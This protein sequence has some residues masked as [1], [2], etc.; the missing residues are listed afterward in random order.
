MAIVGFVLLRFSGRK[1]ITQMSIPTTIVMI[2]IGSIIVQPI[3]E[4]SIINTIA[5]VAMFIIVLVVVEWLQVKFNLMEK[6]MS[7]SSVVV[8]KD[9]KL[10]LDQMRKIRL[11]V[12]KLEMKIRQ[13][14]ITSYKQ[15]KVATI[16]PNGQLGY[17]LTNDAKPLTVGQFKQLLNVM[18]QGTE[19]P[20]N[21][22]PLFSEVIND[23]HST[24]PDERYD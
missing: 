14:G 10:Q 12:D 1:S 17:E 5:A 16:E 4:D 9:G 7:G 18:Q 19:K 21:Y 8:I 24:P 6:L 13:K 20:T 2:S 3:I 22:G 11:T 23:K 15:V